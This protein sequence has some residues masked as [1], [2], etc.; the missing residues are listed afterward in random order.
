VFGIASLP[1]NRVAVTIL[2]TRSAGTRLRSNARP[3]GTKKSRR[4][5]YSMAGVHPITW[6]VMQ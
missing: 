2:R 3:P 5:G 1:C 4:I 6:H